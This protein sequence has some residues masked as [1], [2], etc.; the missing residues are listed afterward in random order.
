MGR[1][2]PV[3]ERA[4]RSAM[5]TPSVE[6]A[7][8]E[9]ERSI[10]GSGSPG[11]DEP[12]H[13]IFGP[14]LRVQLTRADSAALTA[15]LEAIQADLR[16]EHLG[17]PKRPLRDFASRA[18]HEP[19]SDTVHWFLREYARPVQTG[20]CFVSV[21]YLAVKQSRHVFGIDLLPLHDP[22]ISSAVDIFGP[23]GRDRSVAMVEVRGTDP[24][25]MGARAK[26]HV[27]HSLRLLRIALSDL[28][29]IPDLQLRF[30]VGERFALEGG[31]GGWR[32]PDHAAGEL[33]LDDNLQSLVSD[34]IVGSIPMDP[35]PDALK[36]AALAAAWLE[37]AQ[38]TGDPLI[39]VLYQFFALEAILG[40]TSDKEKASPIAFRQAVLSSIVTGRFEHPDETWLLYDRVRSAAVHGSE[41]P[42]V[43]A[44]LAQRH[45]GRVR[46]S[47][48]GYLT[49]SRDQSLLR[50]ATIIRH[51]ELH[52]EAEKMAGWL[53]ANG[54]DQ[55]A[56]YLKMRAV[57]NRSADAPPIAFSE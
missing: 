19:T 51:I 50:R 46:R 47:L 49:L 23:R 1:S 31:G 18:W 52:E 3:N 37:R 53:R 54:G 9:L 33:E 57:A 21:E 6:T 43:D 2:E 5:P 14:Q 45:R 13:L 12:L 48:S 25:M 40:Q 36:R 42:L 26:L 56:A 15:A 38:M 20:L 35:I 4:G 34:H 44:R 39:A 24:M 32:L 29:G 7:L 27:G 28:R 41:A 30:R 11:P 55:W 8:L 16:F 17:E 10:R 22:R